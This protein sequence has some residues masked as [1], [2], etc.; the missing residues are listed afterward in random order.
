MGLRR[1]V[2]DFLILHDSAFLE[3]YEKHASRLKSPLGLDCLG[4][5]VEHADLAGKDDPVIVGHPV[6]TGSE[7]IAIK[8]SSSPTAI[9]K[10]DGSWPIPRLHQ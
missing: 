9:C 1:P 4:W 3:V 7:A 2:L 8:H 5:D 10:Q 6:S